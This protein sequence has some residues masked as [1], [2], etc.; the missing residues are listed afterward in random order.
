ML[1]MKEGVPRILDLL[2]DKEKQPALL[3][4]GLMTPINTTSVSSYYSTMPLI[5]QH[6]AQTK[7]GNL[8]ANNARTAWT[9]GLLDYCIC[10]EEVFAVG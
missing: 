6:N 8:Y 4:E 5:L 9:I 7:P 10:R 3:Q 2:N 1:G